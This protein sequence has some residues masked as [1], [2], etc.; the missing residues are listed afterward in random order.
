MI[1]ELVGLN[2]EGFL[3]GLQLFTRPSLKVAFFHLY[4]KSLFQCYTH[5]GYQGFPTVVSR[6]ALLYCV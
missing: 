5:Q 6:P 1:V 4:S 3:D 2:I